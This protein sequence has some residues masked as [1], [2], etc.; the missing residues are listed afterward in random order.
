MANNAIYDQPNAF[1][2]MTDHAGTQF[3]SAQ[4]N[5]QLIFDCYT[6]FR[7]L[8]TK[9]YSGKAGLREIELRDADDLVLQSVTV[10][11]PL[12]TSVIEL[13]MDIPAGNNLALTT[14][15]SANQQNLSTIS[16]QLRRSDI[17]VNYPY[18]IPGYLS[19]KTS[20]LGIQRYYYFYNWEI[21]FYAY[22]CLSE[23]VPVAVF[24][25]STLVNTA[26]LPGADA[27]RLY[28]NPS[29][30]KFQLEWKNFD[31]GG[32]EIVLCDL[33]GVIVYRNTK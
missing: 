5:G 24:V 1:A 16:P 30:G 13:N 33:N 9:V 22:E 10:D 4:T 27:A 26:G 17:G 11:I 14:N 21:D 18:Q 15:T 19:I 31:G 7:L 23:R 29:A 25:D 28:P 3:A 6:P 2:G 20:D 12:G 8:R 32:L